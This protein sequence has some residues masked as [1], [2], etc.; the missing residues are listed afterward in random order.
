MPF[1]VQIGLFGGSILAFLLLGAT[2]RA[3]KT[4]PALLLWVAPVT[5]TLPIVDWALAAIGRAHPVVT[6][7]GSPGDG[8]RFGSAFFLV[9]CVVE[10]STQL[11]MTRAAG[12]HTVRTS[13][14]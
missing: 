5:L 1:P 2:L 13:R 3:R 4:W 10:I 8:W 12:T 7:D 11:F 14:G 9:L 6:M